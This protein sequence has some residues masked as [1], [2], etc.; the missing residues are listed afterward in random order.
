MPAT[1]PPYPAEFRQRIIELV[2]AG[3]SPAEFAREFGCTAQ[4]R[5]EAN[6]AD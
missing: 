6:E 1:K 2:A 4:T 3:R 5:A